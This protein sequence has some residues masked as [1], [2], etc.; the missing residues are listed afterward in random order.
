MKLRLSVL[1]KYNVSLIKSIHLLTIPATGIKDII[2]YLKPPFILLCTC[3]R[4]KILR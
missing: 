3:L 1:E 4:Y 2:L